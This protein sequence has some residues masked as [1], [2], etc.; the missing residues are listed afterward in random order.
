MEL[1]GNNF[2]PFLCSISVINDG[3]VCTV[4][5][6]PLLTSSHQKKSDPGEWA[7]SSSCSTSFLLMSGP[8][9]SLVKSP[10]TFH[11][12]AQHTPLMN[13]P[14]EVFAHLQIVYTLN[15]STFN[16]TLNLPGNQCHIAERSRVLIYMKRVFWLYIL[17][18]TRRFPQCDPTFVISCFFSRI[19]T[20]G[21]RQFA[22]RPHQS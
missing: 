19:Q 4:Y 17:L 13:C 7:S 3:E 2:S 14:P 5:N 6:T 9:T 12:S 22:V 16:I 10:T 1:L 20:E 11:R 18:L 21:C 15:P 8:A